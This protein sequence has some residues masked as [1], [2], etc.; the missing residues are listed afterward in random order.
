MKKQILLLII[1]ITALSV[2]GCNFITEKVTNK[3][4][5]ELL[6]KAVG[7]DVDIDLDN[8]KIVIKDEDGNE[9][10]MGGNEWPVG[11]A[12]Q[13]IPQFKEGK[14][15]YVTDYVTSAMITITD[16]K[17]SEYTDYIEKLK[18]EGFTEN[19]YSAEVDGTNTYFAYKGETNYVSVNYDGEGELFITVATE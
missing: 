1:L 15:D 13:T 4:A 7:E 17:K 14:I 2:S 9:M 11:E 18:S 6:E 3:I 8:E 12:A 19:S 16:V 10:I 5:G